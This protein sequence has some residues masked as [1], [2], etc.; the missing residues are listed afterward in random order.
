MSPGTRQRAAILLALPAL[1]SLLLF[2]NIPGDGLWR[3]VLLDASHGPIFAAIAVLL[4]LLQPGHVR[5]SCRAQVTAFAAAVAFG[6]LIEIL[7]TLGHRPGS[8]FDL[9]TDAVGAATGLALWRWHRAA[10]ARGRS[11]DGR[12]GRAWALAFALAGITI[13]AWPPLQAVQ[14]YARR[15]AAFP[16]IAGFGSVR[17]LTFVETQ[18]AAA[19]VVELPAP[20]AQSP[21]ERALRIVYREGEPRAVQIVEPSRDWRGHSIL[22]VD[23][24]NPGDS[25]L[26]LTLRIFDAAH[27][28]DYRDRFNLPVAVPPRTRTT[29]RVALAAVEAAPASRRMDLGRVADVMLFGQPRDGAGEFYVSRLWLE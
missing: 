23:L 9:M 21:G 11:Q 22:A 24:T 29:V 27:D 25:A 10:P 8:W 17:D 5:D 2:V 14:A 19:A 3:K 6:G 20:W 15:A 18:G 7:Q 13:V 26:R 4:L 12:A 1:L 28:M 16:V